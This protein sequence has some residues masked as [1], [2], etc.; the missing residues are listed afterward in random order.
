MASHVDG[1]AVPGFGGSGLGLDSMRSF[2]EG[3]VDGSDIGG[4]DDVGY[5]DVDDVTGGYVP[6]LR[7]VDEDWM[8]L[9]NAPGHDAAA[10]ALYRKRIEQC[11]QRAMAFRQSSDLLDRVGEW[12]AFVKQDLMVQNSIT[13]YDLDHSRRTLVTLLGQSAFADENQGDDVMAHGRLQK[14]TDESTVGASSD[15]L[16]SSVLER[17]AQAM[18]L[19]EPVMARD[20]G[21]EGVENGTAHAT[22]DG[23]N[24]NVRQYFTEAH[25][26][27]LFS[28]LLQMAADGEVEIEQG[29]GDSGGS[30]GPP[31]IRFCEKRDVRSDVTDG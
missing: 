5:G 30:R 4:M 20:A 1:G 27:R 8:N 28:V 14:S 18:L 6:S 9:Q 3:G 2:L 19:N 21:R 23:V 24:D 31:V 15:V 17:G 16:L 13:P 10:V 25:V 29:G 12:R 7:H 11:R 26:S 22:G